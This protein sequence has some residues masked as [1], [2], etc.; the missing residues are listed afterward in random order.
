MIQLKK[1]S[2]NKW[3]KKYRIRDVFLNTKLEK[4][5]NLLTRELSF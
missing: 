2:E 1:A 3:I 5:T 4:K